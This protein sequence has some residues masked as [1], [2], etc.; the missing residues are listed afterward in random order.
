MVNQRLRE[1]NKETIAFPC[2]GKEGTLKTFFF[3]FILRA[4][5]YNPDSENGMWVLMPLMGFI[6]VIIILTAYPWV[7]T[8]KNIELLY[9]LLHPLP[10]KPHNIAVIFSNLK[11]NQVRCNISQNK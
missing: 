8:L 5:T 2:I 1:D 7:L 6:F 11:I 10:F 9:Q 4:F 3:Q